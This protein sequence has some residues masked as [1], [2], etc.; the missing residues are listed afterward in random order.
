[1]PL[2]EL[3]PLNYVIFLQICQ[4]HLL[5]KITVHLKSPGIKFTIFIYIIIAPKHYISTILS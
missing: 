3:F 1:M 4:C 2:E 5:I